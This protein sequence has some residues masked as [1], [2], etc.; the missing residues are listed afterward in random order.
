LGFDYGVGQKV[1]VGIGHSTYQKTYDAF[2][3][4]K[5]LRQSTG[6]VNMPVT[7]CYVPTFAGNTLKDSS[8]NPMLISNTKDSSSRVSFGDRLSQAHQLIIGRKFSEKFS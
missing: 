6:K 1:M 4:W 2:F 3:K 5:I 7:V 8:T